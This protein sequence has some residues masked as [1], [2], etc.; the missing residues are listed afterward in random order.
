LTTIK[1]HVAMYLGKPAKTELRPVIDATYDYSL[2]CVF[3]NIADQ[4]KYQ[5]EPLHL[6]FIDDHKADW[7]RVVVYDAE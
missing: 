4:D 3:E 5:A 7:Q 2:T 1:P 6:K